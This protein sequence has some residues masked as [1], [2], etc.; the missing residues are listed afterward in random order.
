M[1]VCILACPAPAHAL[2]S[3]N[4][5]ILKGHVDNAPDNS[6]VRVQLFYPK[7]KE[8]GDSGEVTVEEGTFRIQIPYL[9]Q[10][11]A[12]VLLGSLHEKCD[13]KPQAVVVTLIKEDTEYDRVSLDFGKDFRM[14]DPSAY[15]VNSDVMLRGIGRSD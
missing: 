15:I 11:R 9:T 1:L 7:Q 12:P 4:V 5:V 8:A 14:V 13:R 2:C 6:S 3:T 10:S